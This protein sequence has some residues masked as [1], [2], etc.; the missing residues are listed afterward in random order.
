VKRPGVQDR[1]LRGGLTAALCP[2]KKK[3]IKMETD[4]GVRTNSGVVCSLRELTDGKFRLVLDDVSNSKSSTDGAWKHE[5]VFTWKDYDKKELESHHLSEK[6]LADIGFNLL[7]RL[8]AQ[9]SHPD[10]SLG[11]SY[12]TPVKKKVEK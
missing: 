3:S 9:K 10:V 6:E 5:I 1:P 7:A 11:T 8:L 12:I 4:D 2:F